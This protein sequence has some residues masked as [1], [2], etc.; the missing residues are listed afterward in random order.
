MG[1]GEGT[2]LNVPEAVKVA[3]PLG[4]AVPSVLGGVT[5][6]ASR[7]R[8]SLGLDVAQEIKHALTAVRIENAMR[9]ERRG[10]EIILHHTRRLS[11]APNAS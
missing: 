4:Y 9:S 2:T 1:A 11:T 5:L 10:M 8:P 3:R 6:M 7:M